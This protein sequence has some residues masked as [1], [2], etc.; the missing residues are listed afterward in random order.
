MKKIFKR[1][2]SLLAAG[3]I[4]AA[5]ITTA[6]ADITIDKSSLPD[7]A[8]GEYN[9]SLPRVI[10]DAGLLSDN[11]ERKLEERIG[12]I[13]DDFQ[14]DCV[15]VT[16]KN[17]RNAGSSSMLAFA[18]DFFDYGGYGY[19]SDYDGIIFAVSMSQREYAITTCG[20]GMKAIDDAYGIGW[21]EDD[22]LDD[23][24]D[25]NYYKCFRQFVD[26]VYDFVEE[27]RNNKPYTIGH[28]KFS[29]KRYL[30][31]WFPAAIISLII[32]AVAVALLVGQ[33]KTVLP[34]PAAKPYLRNYRERYSQDTFLYSN[35][36][37][38]RRDSGGG[39]GG[40]GGHHS[41]SGRSHGGHSGRF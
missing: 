16:V 32:T 17:Y 21:I 5:G 38:V 10:D 12:E 24:S 13:I 3:V 39:S 25:G 31:N 36:T 37:K 23:L 29:L 18:D 6:F 41:S 30:S 35:V 20:F 7:Y 9:A 27:A 33:M 40:G 26:D 22:V 11:E 2:T 34:Q 8:D 19:G 14:F 28:T 4:A 1:L 15:I